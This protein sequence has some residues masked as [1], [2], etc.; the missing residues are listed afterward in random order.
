MFRLLLALVCAPV[1]FAADWYLFTSFRKNGETGTY[2][3][4]SQDGREWTPLNNNQP[5]IKPGQPGMQ[6]RDPFLAQ[7]KDGTWHL[8]WTWGWT[9][10]ETGGTLKIG[11]ATSKDLIEWS[12]QEEIPIL[13]K[14][15]EARNAWA[16]EAAWDDKKGEWV[17]FWSTTIP[18]RFPTGETTGDSGYNHRVYAMTTKDW[19]SF[20]P[21]RVW[22]DPGFN[23]IDST[24]VKDGNRYI[25]I[26]KDE[27]RN[28]EKKNLRLAFADSP[29]GPWKDV[30]E[31]F[32][33][34]WVEGP[35]AVK[36]GNDWL[37]YFDRYRERKY[38]ALR[39]SDWKK[40]TPEKVSF[41]ADHRHGTVVAISEAVAKKLQAVS[42]P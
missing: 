37:I 32:S 3:A 35:S 15:P 42:R 6:R 2:L 16:P 1:V 25:M 38:D 26:F 36:I 22:F 28:P 19:K 7:G 5:W 41:P 18:G 31:T 30:T 14:E 40:F 29:A 20:S 21:P 33:D 11:H 17:I 12:A 4:L 39:T 24:V 9:R 34:A 23:C 13:P 10:K 27:R 8:L